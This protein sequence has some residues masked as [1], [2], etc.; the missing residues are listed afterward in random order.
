MYLVISES[1]AKLR[2]SVSIGVS[3]AS[4]PIFLCI[5]DSFNWGIRLKSVRR[6]CFA[7]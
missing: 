1:D 2:V 7:G 4:D 3:L 6:Q 5:S